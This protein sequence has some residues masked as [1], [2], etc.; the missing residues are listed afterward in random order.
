MLKSELYDK[1]IFDLKI[2]YTQTKEIIKKL[3]FWNVHI[4]SNFTSGQTWLTKHLTCGTLWREILAM[5]L[6]H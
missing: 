5:G 4:S 1:T 6:G 2:L 3:I